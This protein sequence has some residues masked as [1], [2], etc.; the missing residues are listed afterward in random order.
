MPKRG[1]SRRSVGITP[2]TYDRLS[3]YIG[4]VSEHG[5]TKSGF[6]ELVVWDQHESL[7]SIVSKSIEDGVGEIDRVDA[8]KDSN[9]K[10]Y[11]LRP[12]PDPSLKPEVRRVDDPSD[13]PT[14]VIFL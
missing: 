11:K 8:G 12:D 1:T 9:S 6:L 5:I 14:G 10:P 3:Y 4:L 7:P 13:P 2:E